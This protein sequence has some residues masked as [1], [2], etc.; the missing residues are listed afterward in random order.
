[1]FDSGQGAVAGSRIVVA[2]DDGVA[3]VD[4]L[5]EF[6]E[7]HVDVTVPG[8]YNVTVWTQEGAFG[9]KDLEI[10]EASGG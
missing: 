10:G 2:S 9:V 5:D 7:F 3:F 4:T 8:K 1:M 6:G